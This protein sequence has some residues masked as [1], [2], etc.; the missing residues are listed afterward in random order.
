MIEPKNVKP[1]RDHLLV[2]VDK[3]PKEKRTQSGLILNVS[4]SKP[5]C[6]GEVI[7]VGQG[8]YLN[9][10]N[11]LPISIEVGNTVLFYDYAGVIIDED[12]TAIYLLI[13]END[14][15]AILK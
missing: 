2:K 1:L 12:A 8:R 9:N 13:K 15:F 11:L 3:P 7:A 4:T 10:G 6:K 5:E 14:V